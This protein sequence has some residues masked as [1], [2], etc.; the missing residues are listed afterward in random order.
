MTDDMKR[1]RNTYLERVSE[2]LNKQR[3]VLDKG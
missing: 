1:Q 3:P 2:L